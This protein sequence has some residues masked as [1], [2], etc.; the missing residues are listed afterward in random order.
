MT[1][2]QYDIY[3]SYA[4]DDFERVRKIVEE[5]EWAGLKV[6]FRNQ[7]ETSQ[8]SIDTLNQ[9]LGSGNVQLVVW[10][11]NSA[12]SGRVQAE[13][14]VGSLKRRLIAVRIDMVLP[15]KGTDAVTYADLTNWT[16]GQD[17]RQVKKLLEGINRLT[18]KG[19]AP[20]VFPIQGV[21]NLASAPTSEWDMLGEEE[22]DERAWAI[23]SRYNNKTYYQHYLDHFPSGKYIQLA[24]EQI[25]KKNRTGR[26]IL[27]CA[28][29][30]IVG[31]IILS[32][33]IQ[34]L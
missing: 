7:P 19:P 28:G 18:G 8:E 34:L 24:Q 11:Q 12:A 10:S 16:G 23:A 25:A 27:I 32:V 15:P 31:Q 26:I 1:G 30:W 13:A 17:H 21:E 20:E 9:T 4:P 3:V 6:W 14:R 5:L 2:D 33:L 22:K 29:I